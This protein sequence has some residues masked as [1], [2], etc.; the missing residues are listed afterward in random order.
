MINDEF[1]INE[2]DK[3]ASTKTIGNTCIIVCLY[4]ND[5]L[6]LRINIEVFKSTKN[7]LFKILI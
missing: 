5:M 2:C 7:M 6:R 1:T 4:V 3:Y